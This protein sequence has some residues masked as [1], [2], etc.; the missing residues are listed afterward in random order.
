MVRLW[1]R[2]GGGFT[3]VEV[4]LAVAV[5][6]II[7]TG[8]MNASSTVR[9]LYTTAKQL[10]EIY[11]VL[12]SCPELDRAVDYSNLDNTTNCLP[13]NVFTAEGGSGITYTYNPSLSVTQ[14]QNLPNSDDL[15]TVP[16]AKVVG[17]SVTN[18]NNPA[19]ESFQLRVLI[20]RNGIGQL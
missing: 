18:I 2:S 20:S 9:Q 7:V 3:A 19:A 12:S 17:I 13:N 8:L 16:N 4:L 10:N 5:F 14:T 11:A 15:S 1:S 6:G